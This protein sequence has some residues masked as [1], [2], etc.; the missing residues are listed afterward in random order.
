MVAIVIPTY[1]ETRPTPSMLAAVSGSTGARSLWRTIGD[2]LSSMKAIEASV[3]E[4]GVMLLSP[5]QVERLAR[6][7]G[8]PDKVWTWIESQATHTNQPIAAIVQHGEA[9]SGTLAVVGPRP[10]SPEQLTEWIAAHINAVEE[11]VGPTDL[12]E[13]SVTKTS[14]L[15]PASET[16]AGVR[17]RDIASVDRELDRVRDRLTSQLRARRPDLFDGSGRP[18]KGAFEQA[19]REHTGKKKLTRGDILELLRKKSS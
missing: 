19:V 6:E 3:D 5:H 8:R 17:P 9:T 15:Y 12:G 14:R 2:D 13:L 4:P 10:W 1:S 16:T 7:I 11:L 18:R